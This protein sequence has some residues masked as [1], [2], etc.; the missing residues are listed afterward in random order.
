MAGTLRLEVATPERLLLREQVKEVTLPGAGGELGILPEHA[1][2]L[3]EL[4]D[5][6][7]AYEAEGGPRR[8]IS[9]CGGYA[10]VLPD[11]VRVL[12]RCAETSDEIDIKRAE[13]ALQRAN[14]RILNVTPDL[15]VA[16]ALNA[17]RR[18]QA[19]LAAAQRAART[20]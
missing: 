2:L 20:K 7:L 9:I 11:R 19:R 14:E 6:T 16:R 3:S 8:F 18:A 17:M 13:A 10:E 15:D 4:G 1:A 12:A 5:G